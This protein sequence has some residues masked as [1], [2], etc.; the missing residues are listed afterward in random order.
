MQ[1]YSSQLKKSAKE[2]IQT[3]LESQHCGIVYTSNENYSL[4]IFVSNGSLIFFV[5]TYLILDIS[6]ILIRKMD[7]EMMKLIEE[8]NSGFANKQPGR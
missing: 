6:P 4:S 1:K 2:Q 7:P 5:F 3:W 8:Y